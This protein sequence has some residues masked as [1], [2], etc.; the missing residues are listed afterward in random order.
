MG[1]KIQPG[2]AAPNSGQ[3]AI[4]GPRGGATNQERT[5]V[6]GKP[7]PPTPKSGQSYVL[8]DGTKNGAG[9]GRK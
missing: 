1:A 9:R 4:V 7:M 3:Y 5:A 2:N 6:R 8:V